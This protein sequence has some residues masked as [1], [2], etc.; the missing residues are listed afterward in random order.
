MLR[1]L[2]VVILLAGLAAVSVTAGFAAGPG[3]SGPGD[4][5]FLA[6]APSGTLAPGADT[7]YQIYDNG[8]GRPLGV[9]LAFAPVTEESTAAVTFGVWAFRRQGMGL[10]LTQIGEGTPSGLPSGVQYWRGSSGAPASYY[11]RIANG[12]PHSVDYAIA[13]T[14]GAFPPPLPGIS[15][16]AFSPDATPTPVS[17]ETIKQP[18]KE[19]LGKYLADKTGRTM[20][21]FA[22]DVVADSLCNLAC[23]DIWPIVSEEEFIVSPPLALRDFGLLTRPNGR[24]QT[25]YRGWPLY[26]FSRD[27]KTGDTRGEGVNKLWFVLK[28]P[29]YTVMVANKPEVGSY[30]VD[31]K[32]RALYYSAKDSP[33]QSTC[34]EGCLTT[35]PAFSVDSIS[36]PS[37]LNAGDFGTMARPDGSPQT[38]YKGLPLYY[39][40]RDGRPGDTTGQ[41]AGEGWLLAVP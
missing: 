2:A 32:G 18:A 21:Y 34:L 40:A 41:G 6:G 35:W 1:R 37:A 20:Y 14:G 4:A 17:N 13:F 29:S 10:R 8:S 28:V 30:L 12:A 31:A 11:V 16:S 19:G 3:G 24:K 15:P 25:T 38:T 5:P 39:Y 7:W 36:A 9:T 27:A 33:G 23:Q 26:F 22:R